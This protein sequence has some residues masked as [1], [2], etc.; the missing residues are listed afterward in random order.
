MFKAK[1]RRQSD[2]NQS[3]P[4]PEEPAP[5][6]SKAASEV[7]PVPE[8][9][10]PAQLA[11]AA[12]QVGDG[13]TVTSTPRSRVRGKAADT[14]AASVASS[15]QVHQSKATAAAAKAKGK[16]KAKPTAKPSPKPKAI[17]GSK[18]K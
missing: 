12:T 9:M 16:A 7:A 3:I 11:A 8:N 4:S 15:A 5:R 1:V 18:K 14:A 17:R 13:G 10:N 2:Q 6:E